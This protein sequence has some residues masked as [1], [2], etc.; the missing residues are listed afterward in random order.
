M[1]RIPAL[2]ASSFFLLI[3]AE[4]VSAQRIFLDPTF[5][6]SVTNDV[7]YGTGNVG[8]GTPEGVHARDLYMDI[9]QPVG[10]GVPD[11]L[12]AA[13]LIPGG[14]FT[15]S[16]RQQV[17]LFGIT[18]AS[19]GYVALT[20][21]VRSVPDLL[22]PEIETLTSGFDTASMLEGQNDIE[23]R[24]NAAAAQI[25]DAKTAIAWL[26][27]NAAS[28]HVDPDRLVL[29]GGSSGARVALAVGFAEAPDDVGVVFSMLGAIPGNE[30]QIGPGDP[31]AVLV[32]GLY[33]TQTPI[34]GVVSMAGIL[35]SLDIP[36]ELYL[37][38]LG[39]DVGFY[40]AG[41]DSGTS[42]YDQTFPFFFDNLNL[43]AIPGGGTVLP[44]PSSLGLVAFAVVG[45][46]G[47][48]VLRRLRRSA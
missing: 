19:R 23:A 26:Q 41:I 47:P 9:Y 16:V 10:G 11:I 34:D 6:V 8:Y 38:E 2:W 43:G 35:D 32:A 46:A 37:G 17:A 15:R 7:V 3:A 28:L 40:L 48:F 29:G 27:A 30:G 22:P 24:S 39:H 21:D 4:Q 20:I 13:I 25:N 1:P 12:P 44:E 42:L 14:G 31:P 36:F 33:D 45:A 5:N 18:M